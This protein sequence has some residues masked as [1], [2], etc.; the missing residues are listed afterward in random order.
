[1]AFAPQ[2]EKNVLHI[3]HIKRMM[4]VPVL[5]QPNAIHLVKE[6]VIQRVVLLTV[7][8]ISKKVNMR[9]AVIVPM[10]LENVMDNHAIINQ[11]VRE[12]IVFIINAAILLI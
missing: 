5:Q 4:H 1:M 10:M 12:I 9:L 2:T 6:A 8:I 3:I 11:N 7:E